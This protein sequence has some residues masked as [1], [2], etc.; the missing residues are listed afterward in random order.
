MLQIRTLIS[1][2]V[3]VSVPIEHIACFIGMNKERFLTPIFLCVS[4]FSERIE[5]FIEMNKALTRRMFGEFQAVEVSFPDI[6]QFRTVDFPEYLRPKDVRTVTSSTRSATVTSSAV[7]SERRAASARRRS[8]ERFEAARARFREARARASASATASVARKSE[9]RREMT[10]VQPTPV[11]TRTPVKRTAT[12]PPFAGNVFLSGGEELLAAASQPAARY[13]RREPASTNQQ[14]GVRAGSARRP[15]AA[16]RRG[17]QPI[18]GGGR[19]RDCAV[20]A[21]TGGDQKRYNYAE[22]DNPLRLPER[23]HGGA[24]EPPPGGATG[25]RYSYAAPAQPLTLPEVRGH[26]C[27]ES[28][29]R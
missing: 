10:R 15:I 21:P 3:C 5:S 26:V 23:P 4:V 29:G 16:G 25:S 20:V 22:P 2:C 8:R 11:V 19:G 13:P 1:M 18:S 28:P 7:T 9:A 24:T 14:S 17:C 12:R 6:Q 27:T